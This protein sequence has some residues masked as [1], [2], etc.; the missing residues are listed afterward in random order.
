MRSRLVKVRDHV[1]RRIMDERRNV[2]RDVAPPKIVPT[3]RVLAQQLPPPGGG[4]IG[5]GNPPAG[6]QVAAGQ[7][8]DFG[9]E[10]VALIEQIISPATWDINGGKGAVV[11]FSPL[12]VLVVSAP[13]EV[14]EP[15][16]DL[17]GQLRAAP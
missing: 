5:P 8:T 17:L 13:S 12:R 16:G 2:K 4:A 9:P 6:A 15:V 1:A 11:Y 3:N 14:H 7:A 10:L